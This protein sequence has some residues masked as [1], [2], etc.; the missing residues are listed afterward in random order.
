MIKQFDLDMLYVTGPGHGAPGILACLW[1]EGSLEKFYPHYA[2]N[3]DGLH[4][5][6]STFSTTAGLPRFESPVWHIPDELNADCSQ[7]YQC[8]D[9]W[10]HSRRWWTGLCI[11]SLLWRSNGQSR[12]NRHLCCRWWWSRIWAN[13]HVSFPRNANFSL[14]CWLDAVHGTRSNISTLRNQGPYSQSFTLMGSKLASEPSLVAWITKNWPLYLPD[15]DT[16]R[17]LSRT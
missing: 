4:Q 14:H 11:G 17:V 1:L 12:P 8:R 13:S 6:I 5:L 9:S 2:R 16:N 15:M 10:C 7:P 3:K